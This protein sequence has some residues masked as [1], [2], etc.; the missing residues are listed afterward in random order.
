MAHNP[1]E[2]PPEPLPPRGT[3]WEKDGI[4]IDAN[5]LIVIRRDE[6]TFQAFSSRD[7]LCG[8]A[9]ENSDLLRKVHELQMKVARA[10]PSALLPAVIRDLEQC[11]QEAD[12]LKHTAPLPLK[13]RMA[14]QA[15][16]YAHA[17]AIIRGTFQIQS[18]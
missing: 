8:L 11:G 17:A 3:D 1:S 10:E 15:Q 4:G 5:G 7:Y 2:P 16:A 14:G 9:L 18:P 12:A 6:T 13:H